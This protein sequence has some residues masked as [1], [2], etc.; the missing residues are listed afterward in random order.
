MLYALLS[1]LMQKQFRAKSNNPKIVSSFFEDIQIM[2]STEFKLT[3]RTKE[4]FPG[5]GGTGRESMMQI[6]FEYQLIS[7][8]ITHFSIE[9][10]LKSDFKVGMDNLEEIKPNTL[11][12]RDLAYVGNEYFSALSKKNLYFISRAKSHWNFYIQ[13]DG[14]FKQLTTSDIINKL[15]SQKEKYIDLNVFLGS[16]GEKMPVRLIANLLSKEQTIKRLKKKSANRKLGKDTLE[17]I[18]LNLFITNVESDKCN[19]DE[20]FQLYRLR[21]QIEL[22]FK[23][24]KSIL[25]INQLHSMNAV[26][27]EC[28]VLVKFIWIIMNWSILKIMELENENELS[29][30][31]LCK[32]LISQR[33]SINKEIIN[34]FD[35]IV[36]WLE[37]IC[38]FSKEHKKEYKK[39]LNDCISDNYTLYCS[40]K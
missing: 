21:W 32:T 39:P 24:W 40:V 37:H 38:N 6:Q 36:Q 7:K 30:H 18:G 35:K 1:K 29:F 3:K 13:L 34:T 17:S 10:A 16:R 5:Y 26:R 20:I 2:D 12:L 22:M 31:K 27:L 19:S 8:K 25:K 11:L 33:M 15:Q 4:A 14:K 9:S 28:T 23:S